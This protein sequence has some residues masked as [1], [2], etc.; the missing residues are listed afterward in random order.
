MHLVSTLSLSSENKFLLFSISCLQ[1][2]GAAGIAA[3]FWEREISAS[4]G[5]RQ[6]RSSWSSGG[7]MALG[8]E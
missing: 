1:L 3:G 8:G 2:G 4:F 5:R 7:S 6:S